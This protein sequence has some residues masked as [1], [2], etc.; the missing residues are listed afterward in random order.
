MNQLPVLIR[1]EFWEHRNTFVILPA[2]TTGFFLLMMLLTL[3][4][5][6]KAAG[7]LNVDI[8]VDIQ[9]DQDIAFFSDSMQADNIYAFALYQLEG[10]SAQERARYINAGLQALGGPLMGILW[11]V[12]FFYLLDSLYDERRDRSILFWKS[13]PVSD[14]M[15][16]I[17]KLVTGLWLLPLIYLLG[18]ALLQIAAM[19]M[20]SI[21]TLGTEISMWETVWGPASIF[22]NWLQYLGALL[23]YSL[24]ALPFFGWLIAVSAYAKSVPLVWVIGVP[25]ALTIIERVVADETLFADWMWDHIVPISF[26]DQ[27]QSVTDN[28][29]NLLLSLQMVSALM[30]GGVLI[31]I[32]IW[33]RGKADEI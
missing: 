28:I 33:L 8:K 27:E 21:A 31:A 1:R 32:A 24:W 5:S 6:G 4:V 2:V 12:M 25:L 11:F 17:S 13:M 19:T 15:T 20:L 14:A 29:W 23:F 16:V 22:S 7:D 10:R 3:L 26:L 30:V 18:V 9:G